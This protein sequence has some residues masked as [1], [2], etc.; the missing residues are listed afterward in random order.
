MSAYVVLIRDRM[1]D[2]EEFATYGKMAAGARAGHEITP[3]A[4]YGAIET[5]EGAPAE[6][7]VI[8]QFPDT[9][10]AK[11][12]YGSPAYQAALQ[13]RLAGADY[14]VIIVEGLA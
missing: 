6:G 9:A 4:F 1:K 2:P 10:A 3:L 14:R 8:L 12:W 7:M 5:L 13:H 11:A